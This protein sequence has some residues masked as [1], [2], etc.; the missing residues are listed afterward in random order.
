MHQVKAVVRL[1]PY[2][3]HQP[4]IWMCEEASP[5]R[6][7]A[8]VHIDVSERTDSIA[9]LLAQL[10]VWLNKQDSLSAHLRLPGSKTDARSA[11]VS[12]NA[13]R[14]YDRFAA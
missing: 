11:W 1:E 9:K 3:G 5:R 8:G 6:R 14:L 13:C 4:V 2:V 7:K 10:A 12:P